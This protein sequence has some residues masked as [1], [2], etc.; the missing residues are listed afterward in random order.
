[1]TL[2]Q[3]EH[4]SPKMKEGHVGTSLDSRCEVA[5][6]CPSIEQFLIRR[7]SNPEKF[8]AIWSMANVY[9]VFNIVL[10]CFTY[11]SRVAYIHYKWIILKPDHEYYIK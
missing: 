9:I 8:K 4:K 11:M 1:M 3:W 10:Q 6:I 2:F 7:E 5:I